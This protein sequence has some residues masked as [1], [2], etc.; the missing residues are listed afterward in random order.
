[1]TYSDATNYTATYTAYKP[2]LA[3]TL[4]N[5]TTELS[6]LTNLVINGTA[7]TSVAVAHGTA[8]TLTTDGT[9]MKLDSITLSTDKTTLDCSATYTDATVNTDAR[10]TVVKTGMA[11]A[12]QGISAKTAAVVSVLATA[13]MVAGSLSTVA[14]VGAAIAALSM[15]F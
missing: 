5:A 4:A 14:S 12:Q 2:I 6:A 10:E 3:L 11:T 13:K 7:K 9:D 8:A 15:S 1:M